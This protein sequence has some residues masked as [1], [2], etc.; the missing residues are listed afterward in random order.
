MANRVTLGVR[1]FC[2]KHQE[3]QIQ[4]WDDAK[5]QV[6]GNAK[7][8]KWNISIAVGRERRIQFPE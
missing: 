2:V 6:H 8:I 1:R 5:S 7:F 4:S 3:P